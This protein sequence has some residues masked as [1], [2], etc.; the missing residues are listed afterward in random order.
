M[1]YVTCPDCMDYAEQRRPVLVPAM[2]DARK[3]TG[4]TSDEILTRFMTGVHARHLSGL[5]I[6]PAVS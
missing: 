3:A 4:E 2:A 6:L 1:T 5:P